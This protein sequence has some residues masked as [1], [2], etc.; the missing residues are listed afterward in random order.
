MRLNPVYKRELVVSSRSIRMALILLV[1]N[2]VLA[3]VALFNMFSVV[4]Q[5]KVTAE[6][7]YSSFLDLYTFVSSVEFLMLLFIMPALTASCISGERERQTLE[8]MLTTTM[9]PREIVL[10]KLSSALTTVLLLAVSALPIQSLVFVY[11][12]ISVTDLAGLFLCYGVVAVL[13]GGLGLFFSSFL[14]RSTI[15][16][17]C[18]YTAIVLLV[19]GTYGANVF[20]YQMDMNEVNSMLPVYGMAMRK[21]TS[22][23]FLYFLLLNPAITF[24]SVIN[25]QA[26]SGSIRGTFEQWFGVIPDNWIISHWALVSLLVQALIAVL[27]IAASIYAVTPLHPGRRKNRAEKRTEHTRQV[28]QRVKWPMGTKKPGNAAAG[29]AVE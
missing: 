26:G 2:S 8:L 25:G 1:F 6:I 9:E 11:G 28:K 15:A 3:V 12:G 17:V 22:G 29:E 19:A 16:T 21:A 5:V 18:T 14:K 4:E 10:G 7:Q 27:L 24:F 13:T 23:G 20:A